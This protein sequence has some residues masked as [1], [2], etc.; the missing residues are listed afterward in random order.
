M[1]SWLQKLTKTKRFFAPKNF[2]NEAS[3][4]KVNKKNQKP[5]FS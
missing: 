2:I 4:K 3:K 5:T 1:T